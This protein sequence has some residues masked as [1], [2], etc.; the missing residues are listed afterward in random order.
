[1]MNSMSITARSSPLTFSSCLLI[2]SENTKLLIKKDFALMRD[3]CLKKMI[4]KYFIVLIEL[5]K[6]GNL[7]LSVSYPMKSL[8]IKWF[9]SKFFS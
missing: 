4:L 8:S 2:I 9:L 1:M 6:K 7:V 3:K 5:Q